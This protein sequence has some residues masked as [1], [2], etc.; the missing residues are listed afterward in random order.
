MAFFSQ[1][2]MV[3]RNSIVIS[4][5]E[6]EAFHSASFEDSDFKENS[7]RVDI[8]RWWRQFYALNQ[9]NLLV[10]FRRPFQTLSILLIPS[11]AVIILLLSNQNPAKVR[12]SN[13]SDS[14]APPTSLNGLGNCNSYYSSNCLQIAF[15]PL[16]YPYDE[17]MMNVAAANKVSY[18][19]D[20]KGFKNSFALTVLH[21]TLSQR[22]LA[23]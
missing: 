2:Q 16:T 3:R 19:S 8:L 20:V 9:K 1:Q 5:S 15:S 12:N 13:T 10:L 18:G 7:I 21:N 22:L 4:P 17:V 23:F 11:L 6:M 14:L